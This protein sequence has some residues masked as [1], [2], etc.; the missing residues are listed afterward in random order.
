MSKQHKHMIRVQMERATDRYRKES[1]S[2]DD[3]ANLALGQRYK[4]ILP[5][6]GS[7]PIYTADFDTAVGLAQEYGDKSEVIDLEQATAGAED[8]SDPA[9]VGLPAD[10]APPEDPTVVA[11]GG[12]AA[13]TPEVVPSDLG[14]A[15]GVD[16]NK[17]G[18]AFGVSAGAAQDYFEGGGQDPEGADKIAQAMET[19]V[20]DLMDYTGDQYVRRLLSAAVMCGVP[21][22]QLAGLKELANGDEGYDESKQKM[23]KERAIARRKSYAKEAEQFGMALQDDAADQRMQTL[24]GMGLDDFLEE[25]PSPD[26]QALAKSWYDAVMNGKQVEISGVGDIYELGADGVPQM[27]GADAGDAG[28]PIPVPAAEMATDFLVAAA[29]TG[30]S[31][32]GESAPA[33]RGRKIARAVAEALAGKTYKGKALKLVEEDDM[34]PEQFYVAVD[35]SA[36][37]E[38][39]VADGQVF[40]GPFDS[41]EAAA[42]AVG[43]PDAD[44]VDCSGEPVSGEAEAEAPATDGADEDDLEDLIPMEAR[45]MKP[46]KESIHK[47]VLADLRKESGDESLE[48]DTSITSGTETTDQAAGALSTKGVND[49]KTN[50]SPQDAGGS[51]DLQNDAKP[52]MGPGDA[53]VTLSA[54]DKGA[55]ET[56]DGDLSGAGDG[57]S[58]ASGMTESGALGFKRGNLVQVFEASSRSK[59]DSGIVV[60]IDRAK[61]TVTLEGDVSYALAGHFVKK[62]Y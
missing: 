11:A 16:F 26:V 36:D 27:V 28:E 13:V 47:A 43:A 7:D 42:D 54:Q 21:A 20:P 52:T 45:I 25:Y 33:R 58:G 2:P 32:I 40:V 22:D 55:I 60:E 30:A 10:A 8:P 18:Q 31:I 14:E 39:K 35:T 57:K 12:M 17:I 49:G 51:T 61:G 37:A 3:E 44:V 4:I 56:N 38:I 9:T 1:V 34:E 29:D 50:Q 62:V 59:I 46:T 6:I 19:A 5:E 48:I 24:M 41:P 23:K 15:T 53:P